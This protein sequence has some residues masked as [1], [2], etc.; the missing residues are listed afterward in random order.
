MAWGDEALALEDLYPAGRGAAAVTHTGAQ[1]VGCGSPVRWH[2][3]SMRKRSCL[4]MSPSMLWSSCHLKA[5]HWRGWGYSSVG[6]DA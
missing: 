4:C 5:F 6:R 2:P 3:N 1:E